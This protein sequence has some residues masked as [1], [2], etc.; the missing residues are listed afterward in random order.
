M[1]LK[2]FAMFFFQ[3]LHFSPAAVSLI[4]AL[5]PLGV[6]A[7][8]LA[9]QPLSK[10][11]GR[12]QIRCALRLPLVATLQTWMLLLIALLIDWLNL[13]VYGRGPLCSA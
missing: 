13:R 5:S 4:G 12:V 11:V 10:R 1:T 2:F 3:V 6:A 9:C 8:S 7:A